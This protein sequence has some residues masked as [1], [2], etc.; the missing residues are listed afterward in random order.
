MRPTTFRLV[1]SAL[2]L[3][4]LSRVCV[5]AEGDIQNLSL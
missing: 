5:F 2:R 3:R 4:L 1:V